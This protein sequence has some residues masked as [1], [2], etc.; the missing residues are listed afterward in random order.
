[1]YQVLTFVLAVFI[2][3]QIANVITTVY[4]HRGL[5]HRAIKF[6]P[7]LEGS[8]RAVLW[9]TTT[10]VRQEWVAVHRKHHAFSDQ[11]GDPH[12]PVVKGFW[13]VQLWN[14][15]YYRKETK[16]PEVIKTYSKDLPYDWFDRFSSGRSYIAM[17]LLAVIFS[18]ILGPVWGLV[19]T[20]LH[21]GT[22][23]VLSAT[24]NG[25][26]HTY[27]YR[28]YDNK[29]T[30]IWTVAL[31]TA[32]EGFHNNHHEKPASPKLGNRWWELDIG[33]MTISMFSMLKMARVR[34]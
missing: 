33:W 14:Y 20:I 23:V 10:V 7:F 30:N 17:L 13:N 19:A 3:T 15:F 9:L 5:A 25:A 8:L 34:K 29:A 26:C 21:F 22:Y 12:S 31:L 27:G 6:N 4:L 32:G 18:L 11:E 24:I 16:N 2:T 28:H 1:M